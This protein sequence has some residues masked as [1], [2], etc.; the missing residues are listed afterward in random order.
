MTLFGGVYNYFVNLYVCSCGQTDM[1][2]IMTNLR[3]TF[4]FDFEEHALNK[5]I[6]RFLG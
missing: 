6:N 4:S 1:L 5:T 3:Y 2:D